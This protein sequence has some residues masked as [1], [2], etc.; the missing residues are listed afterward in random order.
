MPGNNQNDRGRPV[1]AETL[2]AGRAV[3]FGCL[4]TSGFNSRFG[5]LPLQG[6]WRGHFFG[7]FFRLL[8][9]ALS[10]DGTARM[11]RRCLGSG[12]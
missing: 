6:R 3:S 5:A 2:M 1:L 9:K 8:T 12:K 7:D 4:F 10:A 11:M